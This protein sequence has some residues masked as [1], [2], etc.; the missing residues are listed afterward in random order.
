MR[1]ASV[2]T[3]PYHA[4]RRAVWLLT[5]LI[6][7]LAATPIVLVLVRGL[8]TPY[9]QE[10]PPWPFLLRLLQ[11]TSL[12]ALGTAGITGIIGIGQALLIEQVP[13]RWRRLWR[14]V[15]VLP[16]AMPPYVLAMT[17]GSVARPRGSLER[18]LVEQHW[19]EWGTLPFGMF[20]G[21]AGSIVLLALCLSP[22][23]FLPV[24]AALRQTSGHL[25][26][27]ARL[28][29]V[30]WYTR[31]WHVTVPMLTPS[32]FGG[33]VLVFIYALG[34]YGLPSLLRLPTLS[35]AIFSRY[36]G[37]IDQSGTALL[38]LPL[39]CAALG[40][41]HWSNRLGGQAPLHH[42]PT[43]RPRPE[44]EGSR[45]MQFLA[46]ATLLGLSVCALLVPLGVLGAWVLQPAPYA[47]ATQVHWLVLASGAVR[48][49]LVVG[50]VASLTTMIALAPALVLRTGGFWGAVLARIGQAGS[51]MPGIVVALGVVFVVSDWVPWLRGSLLP[52]ILAYIIRSAPQTIQSSDAAF[53]PIPHVYREAARGM[54]ASS[55]RVFWRIMMPLARPG[56]LAGWALIALGLL[57]ELPATLLLRPVGFDTLAVHIWMPASEGMYHAAALPAL[58]LLLG[59]VL[60]LSQILV[61]DMRRD[62]RVEE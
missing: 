27:Q 55:A 57:K 11:N 40:L 17:V 46:H 7:G 15:A 38:S 1:A 20:Y 21:L 53:M 37:D 24:S 6:A 48:T 18:W 54:G 39:V 42:G 58:L 26:E 8:L 35:T 36:I 59:A 32:A 60:P 50:A 56:V 12:F 5:L 31:W 43:W 44:R 2:R 51:A 10:L 61:H 16:L 19:T 49:F 45:R 41:L 13:M 3:T 4:P 62:R 23:V 34:E 28:C 30:P 25:D 47:A 52:L 9:T 22:Y 33:M 14:V 29:G